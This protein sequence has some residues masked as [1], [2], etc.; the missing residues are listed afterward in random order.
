MPASLLRFVRGV[1]LLASLIAIGCDYCHYYRYCDRLDA[2][3]WCDESGTCPASGTPDPTCEGVGEARSCELHFGISDAARSLTVP[4]SELQHIT[5]VWDV[6]IVEARAGAPMGATEIEI[7]VDGAAADCALDASEL[8]RSFRCRVPE[9]AS[10]VRVECS[11][12]AVAFDLHIELT[13]EQCGEA[14]LCPA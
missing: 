8:V 4:V 7:Q 9:G 3:A 2:I 10:A 13:E 14:S 1:L 5:T 12:T 6:V 11:R